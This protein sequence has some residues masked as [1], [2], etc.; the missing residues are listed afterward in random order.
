MSGSEPAAVPI[1]TVSIV[2]IHFYRT[3]DERLAQAESLMV[4]LEGTEHPVIR[5]GDFNSTRGDMVM[6]HLAESWG[7]LRKD[8]SPLTFPSDEP[9]REI[10]FVLVRPATAFEVL[11][12]RVIDEM[13]ASDHR[14]LLVVLRLR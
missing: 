14:P 5:V 11:E 8:G 4:G 3:E 13:L 9:N 10:D 7:I 2:G 6:A 12:H 1:R